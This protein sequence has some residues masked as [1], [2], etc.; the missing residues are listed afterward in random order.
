LPASIYRDVVTPPQHRSHRL[1]AQ[2]VAL[3]RRKQGFESPWE[4]QVLNSPLIFQ[5]VALTF[6]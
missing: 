2:D 5:D 6:V 4:R 3:S 1:A